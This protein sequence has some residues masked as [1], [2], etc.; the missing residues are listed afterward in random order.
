[1]E[2]IAQRGLPVAPAVQTAAADDRR[3]QADGH[4]AADQRI[5]AH[6]LMSRTKRQERSR[7]R[8]AAVGAGRS[9]ADRRSGGKSGN[10]SRQEQDASGARQAQSGETG[11]ATSR[12]S[13]RPAR[14]CCAAWPLRLAGWRRFPATATRQQ[15][16]TNDKPPSILNGV[17]IAQHLN[18]QLPLN[19]TFTDDAGKPVPLAQLLRQEAGDSGA[20]LLPVPDAVLRGAERPDQRACRWCATF[21]ARTSTSSWSASIP[22]RARTWPRPRSAPI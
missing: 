20:G 11:A 10:R 17:G 2:L 19:L 8:T 21:P 22:P 4:C 16:P 18:Q 12:Q 3:Q 7:R 15:G 1:M 5:C 13:S 14:L 9:R 6:R